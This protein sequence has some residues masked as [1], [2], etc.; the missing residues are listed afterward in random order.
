MTTKD[1]VRAAIRGTSTS[2]PFSRDRLLPITMFN[3]IFG[4]EPDNL[5]HARRLV[6]EG[7]VLLDVR[8]EGEFAQGHVEGARNIPVQ[9][10]P[11]R[12]HELPGKDHP[13]VVHCR[14]GARS[15]SAAQMLRRA[16]WHNIH[17]IGGL[18]PW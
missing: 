9:A 18:P 8:T 5:E 16:G 13:I 6:D 15:A 17:D 3:F 10:L 4:R 7:A 1:E 2:N 11:T 12:L 14:S